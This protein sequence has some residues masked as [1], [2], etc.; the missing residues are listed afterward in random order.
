[1]GEPVNA[2][3]AAL[4]PEMAAIIR[5]LPEIQFLEIYQP[6]LKAAMIDKSARNA[7]DVLVE[8]AEAPGSE[9]TVAEVTG[10]LGVATTKKN[11]AGF[12]LN[13]KFLAQ[14]LAKLLSNRLVVGV[15]A[16]TALGPSDERQVTAFSPNVMSAGSNLVPTNPTGYASW[17]AGACTGCGSLNAD[18]FIIG[19]ADSGLDSGPN[20]LHHP[21]LPGGRVRYGSV[22]L[23]QL[24][25]TTCPPA[26]QGQP[27][28]I[29]ENPNV[30]ADCDGNFHGT[31]VAGVAAG[32]SGTQQRDASDSAT[33][34]FLGTGVVPSA[35]LLSTKMTN[36]SGQIWTGKNVYDW[37]SD[38]TSRGVYIQS[39]SHN[40]YSALPSAT[41]MYTQQSRDFDV[42]VRN[43]TGS[44]TTLKPI[45]MTISAG[46]R[47][48]DGNATL[49]LP[50]ATAKNVIAVGG[51]ESV[52]PSSEWPVICPPFN[53]TPDMIRDAN[54]FRNIM[55]DS[56]H[57]TLVQ[58]GGHGWDTY[59]KPDL[60]A[61]GSQ[62]VTLRTTF[63]SPVF[64]A[65]M[66]DCFRYGANPPNSNP[67][68]N[69]PNYF[70]ASGTS[71]SA[72]A[73]AG[74]ALIASRVYSDAVGG[75]PNPAAA[76]PALLKAMLVGSAKSMRTGIDKTDSSVIAARPNAAQG[77][78]RIN[79]VDLVSHTPARQYVNQT[80][81]FAASNQ[82]WTATYTVSDATQPV[83]IVLAWTDAPAMA[84]LGNVFT[85][86]SNDLDLTVNLGN[87]LSYAG[88]N[89]AVVD[90]N[91]DPDLNRGEESILY[92]GVA[93]NPDTKNNVETVIFYPNIAGVTQF[94]VAVQATRLQFSAIPDTNCVGLPQSDCLDQD[95]ALFV[96][97]ATAGGSTSLA[98]PSN[99]SAVATSSSSV[100]ITWAPVVGA[101]HYEISRRTSGSYAVINSSVTGASFADTTVTP[102]TAYLYRVRALDAGNNPGAYSL[103]DLATTVMFTDDPLVQ[104]STVSYQVHITQLRTAVNAVRATAGLAAASF[105]DPTLNN[106][107]AKAV[108]VQELRTNL[109]SARSALGLAAL[110]YTDPTITQFNTTMKADHLSELRAGVK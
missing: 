93:G 40:E 41:G 95:F 38:A 58:S 87:Q 47:H 66:P 70:I 104:R 31:A 72:P 100:T 5:K 63:L 32:S 68:N 16:R 97:N 74:A 7:Q 28:S 110:T 14:D 69:D 91:P 75:T 3:I 1:M 17:L 81:T 37:T 27:P 82:Q 20:G 49:L 109:D 92:S 25:G 21:D 34:F 22:F 23:T 53:G 43:S 11:R 78:G 50:P 13:G 67:P 60:F 99:V 94:T 80:H 19:I 26:P 102:S 46:N 35:G 62:I 84:G 86:L 64:P 79:L 90:A 96:Y 9:E 103:P 101:D 36:S 52:R 98:A 59:N 83:R 24:V 33:G 73:A 88:N 44:G 8:I 48:Q 61:P 15:H 76:S 51:S 45:T 54:S 10:I 42:A 56:K 39:N 2:Y 6:F 12:Y 65:W 77:F 89:L 29:C 55:S 71:F 85:L 18:G 4:T 105:T 30:C 108:H 57:G 107:V 106:V